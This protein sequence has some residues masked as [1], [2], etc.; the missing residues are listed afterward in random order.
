MS[1]DD[2]TMAYDYPQCEN[3]FDDLVQDQA[4]IGAQILSLENTIN[5]LMSTWTGLSADQWQSIQIQ[6]MTAIN[7]MAADL[8]TASNALPEMA[9]AMKRAD[10][11]AAVRIASIARPFGRMA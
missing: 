10:N 3:I 1:T 2:G 6:W 11:A 7:N 8:N 4:T 5:G 9:A